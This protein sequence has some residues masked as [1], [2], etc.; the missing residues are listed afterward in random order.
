M[1]I[2]RPCNCGAFLLDRSSTIHP[3]ELILIRHDDGTITI[4]TDIPSQAFAIG[5]SRQVT[6]ELYAQKIKAKAQHHSETMLNADNTKKP[7]NSPN[8]V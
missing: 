4:T 7:S 2:K 5:R 1:L 6:K 8:E 3:D